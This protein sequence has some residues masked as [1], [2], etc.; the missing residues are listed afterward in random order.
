MDKIK[1][2]VIVNTHGLKGELKVKSF[3]DFNEI[4]FQKQ[5]LL[6][7]EF[8]NEM[9]EMQV[10]SFREQKGMVYITF[11]DLK[12]INLVEQYRNCNIYVNKDD[13][14]ELEADEV[15]Y[16]DLMNCQV[17][18]EDGELLGEVEDV[19]ETGANAVLRVNKSI[20]IPYVNAFVK[21]TDIET[22][23]IIVYKVDGLL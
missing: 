1:I 3:S 9:I 21:S 20:L 12:D 23:K 5:S 17:Y 10:D 14:H 16:F 18:L 7:V 22:K 11:K 15:Y 13:I 6:F 4:R 2:G 19:L 8:H